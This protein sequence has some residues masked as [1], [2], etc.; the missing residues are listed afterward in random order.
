MLSSAENAGLTAAEL[1]GVLAG[2]VEGAV[3]GAVEEGGL[4][5]SN[6]FVSSSSSSDSRVAQTFL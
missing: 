6:R 1:Q 4:Q 3:E 5:K 2:V